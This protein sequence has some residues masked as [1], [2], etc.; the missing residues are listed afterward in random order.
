MKRSL[1]ILLALLALL[2]LLW[3]Q[4]IPCSKPLA[5]CA[6]PTDG[7][8]AVSYD[9]QPRFATWLELS[10]RSDS[11]FLYSEGED[12]YSTESDE[13]PDNVWA[14]CSLDEDC[15]TPTEYLRQSNCFFGTACIDST[16]Q[17]ICPITIDD[18][19]SGVA[20]GSAVMCETAAD[21]DCSSRWDRALDCLCLDGE[22]VSV[23]E[24]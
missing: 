2:F 20:L 5:T 18:N 21:C 17:V 15:N 13:Y 11:R 7:G 22:C 24:K 16:C 12:H 4:K 19:T 10:T 8:Y 14:S 6:Y 1:Y 3:P 23:E 9:I